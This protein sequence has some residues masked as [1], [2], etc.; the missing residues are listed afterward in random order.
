MNADPSDV[1]RLVAAVFE[2]AGALRQLGEQEAATAGQTQAR[3][4][5]LSVVSDGEWTVPRT[6]RRLGITRQSAQRTVEVLAA[7]DL[8]R[9]APNP[10]HARS[11]LLRLTRSGHEALSRIDEVADSWHRRVAPQL[12]AADLRATQATLDLLL[13]E[14]RA[15]RST[16]D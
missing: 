4:Q 15:G 6:A 8:I 7:D 12:S 2:T 9:L 14:A 16:T 1:A 11:P 3:W 5:V 10:D 13:D